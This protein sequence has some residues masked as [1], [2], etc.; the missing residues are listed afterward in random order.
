MRLHETAR[1]EG[2]DRTLIGRVARTPLAN[3]EARGNAWLL[4]GDGLVASDPRGYLGV[5]ALGDAPRIAGLPLARGLRQLAYLDDGDVVAVDPNGFVRTLYRRASRHNFILATEQCNS[6]C[7]MCSQ[8]PKPEDDSDRLAEHLRL[9]D[10]IDPATEELGITGGEPTLFR[11]GF[12]E[13]IARCRERLPATA[14]HVLTN[15]RLFFYRPFAEKLG[16]IAHPDLVLGIPLYSD[17][18]TRHDHIVQAPGAF[19]ETVIGLQNLDRHDVRVEIRVVLHALSIPRLPQL[20][21]FITRNF[22]FACHVALMGM[23]MFG[24]VHRHL[25]EL[26]IDPADYQRELIAASG[27]LCDAG[28]NVSLYNHQLCVLDPKLWPLARRSIS[29]WKNVYLPECDGCSVMNECGG[30]FQ[31]GTKIRSAHIRRVARDSPA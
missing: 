6:L 28:M 26:W 25:G 23:E 22:P 7:L 18:D 30:F 10:L 15:G 2:V 12:L 13:L 21:T 29:D 19:E 1:V 9:I 24:L 11:D 16:R 20:A 27:I 3:M 8:P 4:A 5:L 31:S 14:L 17:I